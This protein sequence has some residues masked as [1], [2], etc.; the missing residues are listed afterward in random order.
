M[1]YKQQHKVGC[2]ILLHN[3]CGDGGVPSTPSAAHCHFR[4]CTCIYQP[5]PSTR[6]K[7]RVNYVEQTEKQW[8]YMRFAELSP[9]KGMKKWS[10]P[11]RERTVTLD[12]ESQ[13]SY[14]TRVLR[15]T[16]ARTRARFIH[17]QLFKWI[18]L[19]KLNTEGKRNEINARQTSPWL[20]ASVFRIS[21]SL[22][23]KKR[24]SVG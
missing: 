4:E 24:N 3:S 20:P 16:R 12:G 15:Q 6:F 7:S 13:G 10:R 5:G 1:Q 11:V 18:T 23:G 14:P 8:Q 2:W 9:L 22:K 21:V 17:S 19:I